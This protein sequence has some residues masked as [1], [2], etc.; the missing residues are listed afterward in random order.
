MPGQFRREG[1]RALKAQQRAIN[2]DKNTR[3]MEME[4]FEEDTALALLLSHH[5]AT[6]ASSACGSLLEKTKHPDKRFADAC[7]IQ[8]Q[9]YRNERIEIMR[10]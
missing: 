3:W 4:G 8:A 10:S 7:T 5:H 1:E 2:A 6:T 9:R